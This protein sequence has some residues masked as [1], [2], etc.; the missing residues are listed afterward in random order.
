MLEHEL[1]SPPIAANERLINAL[2]R[3][4]PLASLRWERGRLVRL[5]V[6]LGALPYGRVSDPHADRFQQAAA[7]HRR[8]TQRDKSGNQNRD[9]D[10]NCKLAKESPQDS[11]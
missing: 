9:A 7:K 2:A 1:Q 10:C 3:L 4:P 8:Q 5:F 6:M 11:A